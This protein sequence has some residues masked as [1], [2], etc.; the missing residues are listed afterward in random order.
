MN[1]TIQSRSLPNQARESLDSDALKKAQEEE[2]ERGRG[3]YSVKEND[4]K[5]NKEESG[6][7]GCDGSELIKTS[8]ITRQAIV[9]W[10]Q[11]ICRL[12]GEDAPRVDG[13]GDIR[14]CE[15]I[16]KIITYVLGGRAIWKHKHLQSRVEEERFKS[17]GNAIVGT[18]KERGC[19]I[20]QL[21]LQTPSFDQFKADDQSTYH[22]LVLLATVAVTTDNSRRYLKT[23]RNLSNERKKALVDATFAISEHLNKSASDKMELPQEI[24]RDPSFKVLNNGVAALRSILSGTLGNVLMSQVEHAG[25]NMTSVANNLANQAKMNKLKGE[26]VGKLSSS[27]LS[28]LE[29]LLARGPLGGPPKAMKSNIAASSAS[30]FPPIPL[31][32]GPPLQE[33][34]N[35]DDDDDN[36]DDDDS[37]C[38]DSDDCDGGNGDDSFSHDSLS[39]IP[40]PP[41]P[42]PG[43]EGVFKKH[44]EKLKKE[45]IKQKQKQK[46]KPKPKPK[47]KQK[48]QTLEGTR[49]SSS[50][51][52]SLF[53]KETHDA[54]LSVPAQRRVSAAFLQNPFIQ[55][56]LQEQH[57]QEK[58][59][60]MQQQ[61]QELLKHHQQQQFMPINMD[62]ASQ[63]QFLHQQQLNHQQE[64]MQ[65][66]MR[67]SQ[68]FFPQMQNG[69]FFAPNGNGNQPVP[70]VMVPA[71]MM[72]SNPHMNLD[73]LSLHSS[74]SQDSHGSNV[75][76][77]SR[78][79]YDEGRDRRVGKSRTSRRQE[80]NR[81]RRLA[82]SD[83]SGGSEEDISSASSE[84]E[85]ENLYDLAD[86]MSSNNSG[87]RKREGQ[88]RKQRHKNQNSTRQRKFTERDV[89]GDDNDD[90]SIG[91]GSN[92]EEVDDEDS[93]VSN[94]ARVNRHRS[95]NTCHGKQ[96][97]NDNNDEEDQRSWRKPSGTTGKL[98]D[99]VSKFNKL[100]DNSSIETNQHARGSSTES[101]VIMRRKRFDNMNGK[102]FQRNMNHAVKSKPK[103]FNND[104]AGNSG[105]DSKAR[106]RKSL[107]IIMNAEKRS[108]VISADGN[109]A[110]FVMQK[111]LSNLRNQLSSMESKLHQQEETISRQKKH[112]VILSRGPSTEGLLG[113]QTSTDTLSVLHAHGQQLTCIADADEEDENEG[114]GERTRSRIDEDVEDEDPYPMDG[115]QTQYDSVEN[116]DD[117]EMA[118]VLQAVVR[119][120]MARRE[121]KKLINKFDAQRAEVVLLMDRIEKTSFASRSR[122]KNTSQVSPPELWEGMVGRKKRTGA[123]KR[124]QASS[125]SLH[126]LCITGML[127]MVM[128]SST[129]STP[130]EW[131]FGTIS[132]EDA[133]NRL[134]TSHDGSFLVR[135][136]EKKERFV[137]CV[138]EKS[139]VRHFLV[140]KTHEGTIG[141]VG[142]DENNTRFLRKPYF[143]NVKQL[144]QHYIEHGVSKHC[145]L[146]HPLH[147]KHSAYTS[148]LISTF[149]KL[150]KAK[151][152]NTKLKDLQKVKVD[153]MC[154]KGRK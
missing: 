7:S 93:G 85:N 24:L 135:V 84:D 1:S 29:L 128:K 111:E 89:Y 79:Y 121:V 136:S 115:S 57:D 145:S 124:K 18:F 117:E 95:A 133:E 125:D 154:K 54:D 109:G 106:F 36:N 9:E 108:S 61:Q 10:M 150:K 5:A 88:R 16:A 76:K 47:Q 62:Y 66:Q 120:W 98:M 101:N 148:S 60:L 19:D 43:M 143:I 127:Q 45:R 147:C 25:E 144:I 21:L 137:L 56:Q 4:T 58:K 28:N 142:W 20:N 33:H 13:I 35:D 42:P 151:R 153:K 72:S 114:E 96:D 38:N 132:R 32:P 105:E 55:H 118:V 100:I 50:S 78:D 139:K 17:C 46:Q 146:S 63:L 40:P 12:I 82:Y 91:S 49:S 113:N 2:E 119:G 92:D 116:D 149:L 59:V 65:Q 68:Q 123:L 126:P 73:S 44:E 37:N 6:S 83:D 51:S 30:K 86:D 8:Q 52:S 140:E 27:H 64:Q 74:N 112:I 31:Q 99:N 14:N 81:R 97:G 70:L 80:R 15:A 110:M 77:T 141:L 131:F 122:V 152:K 130:Y 34:S 48:L 3:V 53:Q 104:I 23:I 71:H 26:S 67:Q 107:K 129:S 87:H 90:N 22:L 102:G 138:R 75:K 103:T 11:R 69:F 94:K 39:G 41:P 134:L